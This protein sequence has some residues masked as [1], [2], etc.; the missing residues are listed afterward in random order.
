VAQLVLRVAELGSNG[1]YLDAQERQARCRTLPFV[2]GEWH[3]EGHTRLCEGDQSFR[4]LRG[5]WWSDN[6]KVIQIVENLT[7]PAVPQ[8]PL[9]AI[10]QCVEDLRCGAEAER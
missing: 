5:V 7:D 10:G 9:Q 1:I 4:T 6:D 2:L 3:T 8:M